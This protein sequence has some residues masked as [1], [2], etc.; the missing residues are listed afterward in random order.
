MKNKRKTKKTKTQSRNVEYTWWKFSFF[1][2]RGEK[3]RHK[4]NYKTQK[5]TCKKKTEMRRHKK[6]FGDTR[7]NKKHAHSYSRWKKKKKNVHIKKNVVHEI[8]SSSHDRGKNKTGERGGGGR[9]VILCPSYF[10][11][12][13]LRTYVRT[14]IHTYKHA[15]KHTYVRTHLRT[16][17]K[18]R[19]VGN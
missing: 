14:S 19:R 11:C 4:D 17:A 18:V 13:Y 12:S 2:N 16:W 15:Y 6:S 8:K 10:Q 9:T 1:M 3:Q 7:E 5:K